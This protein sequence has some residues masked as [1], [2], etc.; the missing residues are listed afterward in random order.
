MSRIL[1]S[2]PS[3]GALKNCK[4][5]ITQIELKNFKETLYNKETMRQIN[6]L[7]YKCSLFIR[8]HN[9][10]IN[11]EEKQRRM[12]IKQ[13]K[14]NEIYRNHLVATQGSSVLKDFF[15]MRY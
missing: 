14:E 15:A 4:L 8:E 5:Y 7:K 12:Q 2:K 6:Y 1:N 9:F 13:N 10:K 11:E 3:Q